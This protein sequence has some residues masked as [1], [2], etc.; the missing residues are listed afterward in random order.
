MSS[1][2]IS[3]EL[4]G[5]MVWVWLRNDRG[6]RT[7]DV[8]SGI[9]IEGGS[10]EGTVVVMLSISGETQFRTVWMANDIEEMDDWDEELEGENCSLE[11]T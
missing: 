11:E 10:Q 4:I 7:G 5:K 6:I 2:S 3:H 1:L 8:V 9:V